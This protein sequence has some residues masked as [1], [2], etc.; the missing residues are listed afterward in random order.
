MYVCMY[1][2]VCNR[3]SI[4][5]CATW[6][7]LTLDLK[8]IG[9]KVWHHHSAYIPCRNMLKP[10]W[11]HVNSLVDYLFPLLLD[12]SI[13]SLLALECK[14]VF[15]LLIILIPDMVIVSIPEVALRL[16]WL[17]HM[18]H[19]IC[20]HYR[21]FDLKNLLCYMYMYMYVKCIVCS[22]VCVY[23]YIYMY[24]SSCICTYIT[25]YEN[26]YI[27]VYVTTCMYVCMYMYMY[28]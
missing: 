20:C 5:P 10:V 16:L 11:S 25:K 18:P 4:L 15:K 12:W 2:Y 27:C 14:G 19:A 8:T 3:Y 28:V 24:M 22:C 1:V 7:I 6:N 21:L 26:M 13:D 9:P 23:H 17:Y